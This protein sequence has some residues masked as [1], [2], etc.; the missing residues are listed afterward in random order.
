MMVTC[1]RKSDAAYDVVT[2]GAPAAHFQGFKNGGLQRLLSRYE[3][4]K[5]R[6]DPTRPDP[7]RPD[8]TP[9]THSPEGLP[10]R[11]QQQ[12]QQ[13]QQ[14]HTQRR[15]GDPASARPLE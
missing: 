10:W 6:Y 2:V 12:Q 14:Q 8:P 11:Q 13:Q 3:A 7:T 9:T 15:G 1:P 4:D 5:K